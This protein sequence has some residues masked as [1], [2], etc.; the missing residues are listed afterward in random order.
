MEV[1]AGALTSFD[2]EETAGWVRLGGR[3]W[4]REWASPGTRV[5][6]LP[7]PG[8]GAEA[9]LT[10]P[11]LSQLARAGLVALADRDLLPPRG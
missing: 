2:P 1:V 8:A 6:I 7:R 4:V 10:M 3:A 5:S 11:W 9:A